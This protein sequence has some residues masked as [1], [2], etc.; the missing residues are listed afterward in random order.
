[1]TDSDAISL[2]PEPTCLVESLRSIGYTLETALADLIDNSIS[3]NASEIDIHYRWNGGDP[4]A[5]VSDNG[6][7]MDKAT[8]VSALRFGSRN[9]RAGR[10]AGDLGRYGLGLKTASISQCRRFSVW[11]RSGMKEAAYGWDIDHLES[12]WNLDPVSVDRFTARSGLE[13]FINSPGDSGT[14][15]LWEH[16]DTVC[17]HEESRLREEDF[18]SAF[19]D[20]QNH[21][22]LTFH[23]F[24]EGMPW[25]KGLT[26]MALT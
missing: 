16:M 20:A 13:T 2:P 12:G 11:S 23:R 25:K 26:G 22:A 21:V 18:N 9:P 24:I 17:A 14:I 4:W 8:L 19:I 7:G 1:M 6:Q 5:A 15:V 10:A 3:A